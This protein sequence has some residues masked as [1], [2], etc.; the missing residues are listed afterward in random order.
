MLFLISVLLTSLFASVVSAETEDLRAERVWTD[1]LGR[2]VTGTWDWEQ[3]QVLKELQADGALDY[4][5][6]MIRSTD[7]KPFAL[8]LAKLS[9]ED[10]SLVLE[11]RKNQVNAE[12]DPFAGAPVPDA[13]TKKKSS[14][15]RNRTKNSKAGKDS[16]SGKV[17]KTGKTSAKKSRL[18]KVKAG[19]SL[20]RTI[21]GVSFTFRYCPAGI[22]LVPNGRQIA[23]FRVGEGFWMLETEV[24]QAQW[25]A[26]MG[27]N[28]AH[29]SSDTARPVE[30]VNWFEANRFCA[31][32]SGE[33]N[34]KAVLPT[35]LQWT[36]AACAGEPITTADQNLAAKGWVKPASD[37]KT[38]AAG[39]LQPN[40]WGLCDVFGNV[41]EW[42]ADCRDSRKQPVL[43][44]SPERKETS[45]LHCGGSWYCE[46][47]QL[48]KETWRDA[49]QKI[50]DVGF[51]FCVG[52]E[53]SQAEK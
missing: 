21:N 5:L 6:P 4:P 51:R 43:P 3:E 19:E 37:G 30:Q 13:K 24:T 50:F 18:P 8:P 10:R 1:Q 23:K 36:W 48:G 39:Q 38:H 26:V 49:D 29:F 22:L 53:L 9:E 46:T 17:T 34:A 16:G 31:K 33:L 12:D 14:L 35:A 15:S 52:E 44:D 40:A 7:E 27:E 41:W 42:C 2:E 28:P 47:T 32:I 45:A 11:Y 20:S 25:N